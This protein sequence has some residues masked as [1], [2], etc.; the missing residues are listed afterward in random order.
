MLAYD[1]G[2]GNAVINE[3][4]DRHGGMHQDYN[5]RLAISGKVQDEI[6]QSLMKHKFLS[7]VPPKIA[8]KSTFADKMEHLE[9]LSLEDGAATATAWVAEGIAKAIKDFMPEMPEKIVVC[10]NGV[11][12]PTLMRFIRQKMSGATVCVAEDCGWC[13]RGIEPQA[14][15]F[16][17]VRRCNRMPTSYPFTTGAA[18]EVIGGEVFAGQD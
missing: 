6:M 4:V 13:A 16:L 8:D 18:G 15:A 1:A 12:N 10:G 11:A 17:A 7:Q 9:G 14:F 5:G 3:W 2:P